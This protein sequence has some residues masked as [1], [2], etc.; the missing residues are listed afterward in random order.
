MAGSEKSNLSA[1]GLADAIGARLDGDGSV[2][3]EGVA[4]LESAGPG[5]VSFLANPRYLA[6]ARASQAGAL[7]VGLRDEL[8]APALLRSDNPYAAF[9]RAMRVFHP[10]APSDGRVSPHAV[11]EEGA[12]LGE[13]VSI[14]AHAFVGAGA[15]IGAG[16]RVGVGSVVGR[17]T[18]L[19]IDCILH[20][21]VTLYDDVSIGDRVI[22]HSGAVIGADGFGFAKENGRYL[23]IPQVGTVRI[24]DDVEIGANSTVDRATLGRTLIGRGSKLDNLVQ[25]AHNVDL[26]ED[27]ALAAQAGIAGSTTLGSRA[28]LA[29]QSGVAG[30][31]RLGEDVVVSGKTAVFKNLTNGAFVSGVPARPHRR[32]LEREAALNRAPGTMDALK[33]QVAGLEARLARLESSPNSDG[34]DEGGA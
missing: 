5:H 21:N 10:V 26:G 9:A 20:A 12:V 29:G 2:A 31:L 6:V 7:I 28:T 17:N 4:P 25:V 33:Q 19:G 34:D 15:R 24:E 3:L 8:S 1:A 23:K 32:W 18:T 27:A 16:T 22:L 11:V 14:E 30:H 13:R